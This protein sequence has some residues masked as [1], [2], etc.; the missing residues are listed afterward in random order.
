MLCGSSIYLHDI[1]DDANAAADQHD[2]RVE[3]K[4]G[5]N[6]TQHG[7]VDENGRHDPYQQDASESSNY[8][9]SVKTKRHP[10]SA[11]LFRYRSVRIRQKRSQEERKKKL[12]INFF[13]HRHSTSTSL[14][15]RRQN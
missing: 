1:N 2:R 7:H 11:G 12:R 13:Y 15:F 4:V 8:F 6:Y 5:M 3:L 9:R 10:S 14:V